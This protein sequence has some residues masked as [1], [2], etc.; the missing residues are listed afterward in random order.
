MSEIKPSQLKLSAPVAEAVTKFHDS[1]MQR[2]AIANAA[3]EPTEA[4]FHYTAESAL[5]SIIES[6]QFWFTS[7]YHMDDAEELTFGFNVARALLQEA[8]ESGDTLTRMFCEELVNEKDLQ[9]IKKL[10]E[11]YS[12]SFGVRD[13]AK[14]W[15]K[16]ADEGRG[17]TL[18]LAPAFFKPL[19]TEDPKPKEYVFLGKVAYGDAQA[20]ARHSQVI[21]DAIDTIQRTQKA[22]VIKDGQDARS[23]FRH[24]AAEMTV[25]TL[26]NSVT[27]KDSS[28]SH[29]NETR[30]LALNNLKDPHLEI[31]N[32]DKRPRVEISQPLLKENITEVMIGP[33]AD[34]GA[35]KRV[36]TFLDR[37]DLVDRI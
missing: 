21:D 36:R 3:D 25:E 33:N 30:L 12:V 24:I 6:E 20:R 4:L 16:Y 22:G 31:H 2:M 14:Q 9:R 8:V 35:E 28:W 23:F 5:F 13:D 19:P 26:W 15:E 1:S 10:F 7:I 37:H 18:G 34:A 32:A 29:Q 27:T 11:F 17:V